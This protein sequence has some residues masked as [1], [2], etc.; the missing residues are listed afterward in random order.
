MPGRANIIDGNLS[1]N[2]GISSTSQLT[3]VVQS[4][5]INGGTGKG[6]TAFLRGDGTWV[7]PSSSGSLQAPFGASNNPN[8]VYYS[9]PGNDTVLSTYNP[10]SGLGGFVAVVDQSSNTSFS[11]GTHGQ[12]LIGSSTGK[13][14]FASIQVGGCLTVNSTGSGSLSLGASYALKSNV[15]T[16]SAS[17]VQMAFNNCYIINTSALTTLVLPVT[18]PAGSSIQILGIGTGNWV[19]TQNSGQSIR[20][21]P[22]GLSTTGTGGSVTSNAPTDS[23]YLMCI[24]DNVLWCAVNRPGSSGLIV[25]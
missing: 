20:V 5:N 24:T 18:A 13:P 9:N 4:T 22:S 14:Q 10:S 23:I 1:G 16:S 12:F 6:N 3:G 17:S 21:S 19:I 15:V 25:V 7:T 8:I 11:H 2:S